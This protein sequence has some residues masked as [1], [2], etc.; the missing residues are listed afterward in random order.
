MKILPALIACLLAAPPVFA[1]DSG[2]DAARHGAVRLVR[3]VRA[4]TP[5]QIDGRL[6]DA[7]WALAPPVGDFRQR[8]P[9]EGKP[10]TEPT[11][12]RVAYDDDALYVGL[13]MQDSEP[14]RIVRRLSR[15]DDSADADAV[16][17]YLD[18]RLDH[19]T[20]AEFEVTAAGVQSDWIIYNDS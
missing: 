17:L 16:R 13:R 14:E 20:G 12:L 7:A 4:Q 6:D 8:D 2:Q 15:R 3:A 1:R 9:Q 11:E 5:I 19:Q 18:P 10:A